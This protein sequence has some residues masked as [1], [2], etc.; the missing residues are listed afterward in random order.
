MRIKLPKLLT[1]DFYRKDYG[2]ITEQLV[3][4]DVPYAVVKERLIELL[5]EQL[6]VG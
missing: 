3:Q 4:E 2:R 6:P 1:T 5:E